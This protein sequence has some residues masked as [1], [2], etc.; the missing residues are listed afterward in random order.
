MIGFYAHHHG[1]GHLTRCR[2]IERAMGSSVETAVLSSNPRADVVLPLDAPADPGCEPDRLTAHGAFHWAPPHHVGLAD[3]M[4][5][6]A[7]WIR[8]TRPSVVHVDVSVEMAVF[9]RSM[10]VPV[11]VQAMPGDRPDGPHALG[12][13][14]ADAIIAAWPDWVE[15]PRHLGPVADRVHAVGGITRWDGALAAP[16]PAPSTPMDDDAGNSPTDAGDCAVVI[17]LGAGGTDAPEAYWHDVAAALHESGATCTLIGGSH[18]VADPMPALRTAD[19]V[20]TA[21][22]QNSIADLAALRKSIVVVP[23]DRPFDEQRATA[24]VLAD[25]GLAV[26]PDGVPTRMPEPGRWP[27]IIAEARRQAPE[28]DLWQTEGAAR[29]AAAVILGVG[30]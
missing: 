18:W 1:A 2:A 17:L 21:A 30:T 3:R 13:R 28:W 23:Q 14:L 7:D 4:A 29:R 15:L 24:T 20:V 27:G 5:R 22:G 11:T 19:V 10:G 16:P 8:D 6:V 26:L 9:I 12:Y 25:A